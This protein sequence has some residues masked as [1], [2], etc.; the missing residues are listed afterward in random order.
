MVSRIK[1]GNGVEGSLQ[2]MTRLEPRVA[3]TKRICL[4]AILSRSCA[5]RI[6][7]LEDYLM[8]VKGHMTRYEA[9]AGRPLDEDM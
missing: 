3:N 9:L 1:D 7:G 8:T 4:K 2:I 5:R 6:E